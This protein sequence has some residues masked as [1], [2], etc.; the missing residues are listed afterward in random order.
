MQ[1]EEQ[2]LF[3]VDATSQVL[4]VSYPTVRRM[5]SDGRLASVRIGSTVRVPATAIANYIE[6]HQSASV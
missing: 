6:Q 3:T 2:A 5:L 1:A 4:G